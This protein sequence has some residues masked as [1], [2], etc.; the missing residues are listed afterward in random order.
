MSDLVGTKGGNGVWQRIISEMPEHDVYIEPFWGR[1]TIA[2]YKRPAAVT[3]G[4]DLDLDAISSGRGLGALMLQTCGLQFLKDYFCGESPRTVRSAEHGW[5]P[6]SVA[7]SGGQ[8]LSAENGVAAG[9]VAESDGTPAGPL[10]PATCDRGFAHVRGNANSPR[11]PAS[12]G[13][14][15]WERHFVY[16]DPPY[17][18]CSGYYKHE[19]TEAEH[20]ELCHVFLALPCPAALS[21]YKTDV[22]AAELGDA[23]EIRIPTVNRAGR[24]VTEFLWLNFDPPRR[25]H[26][27]RFVGVGRRQRERIR[28][29]VKTWSEGLAKMPPAERQAVF[30]ACRQVAGGG[31]HSGPQPQD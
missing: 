27:T 26:D 7:G 1:G 12:F 13:G 28:R 24:R 19:L 31:L 11:P 15:A 2:R 9:E 29:R 25:Y 22:H 20:R 8:D 17:L 10:D 18:G 23:R 5:E 3:V 4:C 6:G 30:E 14:F 21:G 16:I